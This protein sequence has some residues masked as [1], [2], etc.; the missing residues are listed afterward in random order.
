MNYTFKDDLAKRMQ[1]PE[2]KKEYEALESEYT[3]IQAII[4]VRK[5]KNLTQEQLSELTGIDQADISKIERGVS[6]PTLK[7]LRKLADGMGMDLK[8]DFIPKI[9]NSL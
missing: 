7:L 3:I 4:D 8:I 9:G 6:N 2:F 1:N 5:Q